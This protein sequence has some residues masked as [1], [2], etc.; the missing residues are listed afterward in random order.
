MAVL[1]R[2]ARGMMTRTGAQAG[3]L[4]SREGTVWI[5]IVAFAA[6]LAVAVAFGFYNASLHSFVANKTD[7]KGTALG[8]VDAFVTDYSIVR[9]D[10]GGDAPVPA[11][12]RAHS[13][14][15]FNQTR[16]SAG[17]RVRWIGRTGRSIATPPADPEMAATIESFVGKPDPTPV[18]AFLTVGGEEVF[19]T[20]YPSIAHEQSCVDCHN[21]LQPG[22][23]WQ[24]NDVMGAFSLD[25][26][27]GAFLA[28][29]RAKCIMIG[30]ALFALISGAGLFVSLNYYHRIRERETAQQKAEAANLAKSAFLATMS[31]EL[32]T[33]LNAVIGF[34]EMMRKAV[35]GRLGDA[36]YEGYADAIFSSGSHLLDIINDV[37]DLSKA[38]SGKLELDESVFDLRDAVQSVLRLTDGHVHGADLT[39]TVYVPDDLPLLRGD[40]RK[41]RQMLLNL[42]GNAVKFTPPGGSISL[43]VDYDPARGVAVSVADTGIG[44][45]AEDLDRVLEPFEQ[46][47]S[48][49]A[50]KHEGTGLGLALVRAM[51]ELHGGALTL[52]STLGAG[53]EVT[54]AFPAERLVLE[55]IAAPLAAA[56]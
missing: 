45:A 46:A 5:M 8:L 7:E 23:D 44:I 19:R 21:R 10:L 16:A 33:P 15:L 11:T 27:V 29:L 39:R 56:A 34:S 25:V 26:P 31:H 47:D 49:L 22:L 30:L 38:E 24:L 17:L 52:R 3:F 41:T 6:G 53:T 2:I 14:D 55:S 28:D 54:I 48:S 50:R 42:L 43:F 12:F 20:V 4:R 37:L 18:S 40:E 1:A 32:R 9:H 51:I 35:F 13:I 36:R